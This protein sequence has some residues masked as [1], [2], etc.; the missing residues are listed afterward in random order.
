[1][2]PIFPEML[3]LAADGG[4]CMRNLIAAALCCT[5]LT[6]AVAYAGSSGNQPPT[7]FETTGLNPTGPDWL[8][9]NPYRADAAQ[10]EVA[11]KVGEVGYGL[12]CARCH[13]LKAITGGMSPD[14]RYLE[15]GKFG[16]EWYM[17]RTRNGYVHNGAVKMP[18]YEGILSQEGMWAIRSYVESQPK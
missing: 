3:S 1:M 17:E 2:A 16:D 9:E 13:G 15:D 18:K 5:G 6:I 10:T 7:P 4:I 14:L 11:I 12:N 8:K